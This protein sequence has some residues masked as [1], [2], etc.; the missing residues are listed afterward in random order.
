MHITQAEEEMTSEM[1]KA[2]IMV[3]YTVPQIGN[4]CD[5]TGICHLRKHSKGTGVGI[6]SSTSILRR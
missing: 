1:V 6:L 4:I 2:A 5:Y 3:Y